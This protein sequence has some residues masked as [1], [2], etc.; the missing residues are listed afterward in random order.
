MSILTVVSGQRSIDRLF[1]KYAGKEGFTSV[2]ISG[3]LFNLKAFDH[4]NGKRDIKTRI[5]EIRILTQDKENKN[6]TNFLDFIGK[7]L[8]QMDYEEF[9]SVKESEQDLRILVRKQGRKITEFILVAG[10]ED[11]AVIQIKGAM[12]F[13]DARE[14]S[15]DARKNNGLNVFAEHK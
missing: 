5:K 4:D 14:L 8:D 3:S 12:T 2:S 9:M 6:I 13:S 7:D 10:G 1:E 11:N 15:K